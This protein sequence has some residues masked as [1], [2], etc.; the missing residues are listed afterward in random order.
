MSQARAAVA[1]QT[2]LLLFRRSKAVQQV[3]RQQASIVETSR[4]FKQAAQTLQQVKHANTV[5][6]QYDRAATDKVG[7]MMAALQ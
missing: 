7:D 5:R 1:D 2:V 6:L 3:A 4:L